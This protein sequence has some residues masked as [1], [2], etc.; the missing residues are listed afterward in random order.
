MNKV[1]IGVI[2]LLFLLGLLYWQFPYA[3]KSADSKANLI[4]FVILAATLIIST[5]RS[6]L[7]GSIMLRY[8]LL[9]LMIATVLVLGYSFKNQIIGV[10]IPNRPQTQND[11]SFIIGKRQDK[12][13]HIEVAMNNRKLDCLIDTGASSIVIDLEDA[14]LIGI[15]TSELNFNLPS[16]TA[17]GL[18]YSARAIVK[19]VR[20]GDMEL[21]DLPISVNKARMN[22]CLLGMSFLSTLK[23]VSIEGDKM[24]LSPQ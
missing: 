18:I 16:E 19:D 8:A 3:I 5:N 17:N 12:H 22:S 24:I 11:G 21:H 4:Y 1:L 10:L 6:N 23:K 14:N 2:L 13:F 15:D 7:S 20:I 9:W